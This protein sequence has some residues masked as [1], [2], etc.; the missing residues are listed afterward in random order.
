MV[1]RFRSF[2]VA[3]SWAVLFLQDL[4]QRLANGRILSNVQ[5]ESGA[6]KPKGSPSAELSPT[7]EKNGCETYLDSSALIKLYVPEVQ[8]AKVSV[9]VGSLK[10]PLPFSHLHDLEMKNGLRLKL[11]RGEASEKSVE[12]AI[13]TIEGDH[14]S[15]V[16]FRPELNWFDVFRKAESLSGSHSSVLGCRSLDLLH[17]A[18]AVLLKSRDFLTFDERQSALAQKAGLNSVRID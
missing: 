3:R 5:N 11:F 2:G 4:L 18:S 13:Q 10:H 14:S 16:L 17:V 9:F 7:V 1:K 12:A 15:G 8:S 6:G